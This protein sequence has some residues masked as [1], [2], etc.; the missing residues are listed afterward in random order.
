MSLINST[1]Y[2]TMTSFP[3]SIN[4]IGQFS[5][6]FCNCIGLISAKDLILPALTLRRSCYVSMFANC[7]NLKIAP[8]LPAITLYET[9]YL[10]MFKNC[11]NLNYIKCLATNISATYC[12]YNWVKGVSATGTFV[13]DASMSS[14]TTGDSGIP[15]NWTIK[16]A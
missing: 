2:S 4:D 13:K 10:E 15:T 9:C 12:L 14:W 7:T 6:L 16:N 3:G 11:S 5:H 1:T 8:E